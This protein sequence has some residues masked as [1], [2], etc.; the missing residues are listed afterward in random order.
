MQT[1]AILLVD[2]VNGTISLAQST[3]AFLAFNRW[4]CI[5]R[6]TASSVAFCKC[7]KHTINTVYGY[8]IADAYTQTQVDTAITNATGIVI[9]RQAPTHPQMLLARFLHCWLIVNGTLNPTA[10]TKP[11]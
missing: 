9:L 11:N 4:K 10:L 5:N 7:N 1:T 3:G 6:V 2:G 8:G